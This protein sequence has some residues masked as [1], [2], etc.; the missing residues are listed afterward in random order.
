[1]AARAGLLLCGDL[2]T[3]M[4]IVSTESREIAGLTLDA[5][6]RDL[7]SFCA[8]EEHGAL[9]ARFAL[10]SHESARP[11]PPSSTVAYSP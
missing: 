2:G 6:R 8:S 4:A 10:A 7:V 11:P 9:R 1:M 5:K 3:A